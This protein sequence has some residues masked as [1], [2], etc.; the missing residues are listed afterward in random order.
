MNRYVYSLVQAV[1]PAR[2]RITAGIILGR[3]AEGYTL[4]EVERDAMLSAA[5][6]DC[7]MV[8]QYL[9]VVR[10]YTCGAHANEKA[11]EHYATSSYR[12][13]LQVDEPMP[14]LADDSHRALVA[15]TSVGSLLLRARMVD[16]ER[17]R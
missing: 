7:N 1:T 15:I 2:D 3:D 6:I 16:V 11:L 8:R 13:T 17:C 12:S 14:V 4:Y 5:G 9:T 10:S